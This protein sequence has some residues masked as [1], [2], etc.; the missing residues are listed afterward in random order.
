[1]CSYIV[2]Y[3]LQDFVD[4]LQIGNKYFLIIVCNL[5][6]SDIGIEVIKRGGFVKFVDVRY[7]EGYFDVGRFESKG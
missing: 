6:C 5:F 3:Y 7:L 2:K 4:K 1:M